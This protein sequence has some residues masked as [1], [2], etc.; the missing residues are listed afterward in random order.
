MKQYDQTALL[1]QQQLTVLGL[2]CNPFS[3]QVDAGCLYTDSILDMTLN[4][5]VQSL[6]RNNQTI[7]L[8]AEQGAGK[9]T[10]LRKA[11]QLTH[12]QFQSCAV[13]ATNTL[14][15]EQLCEK[16]QTKWQ[17]DASSQMNSNLSIEN[18]LI[19]Y[20]EKHPKCL[21]ILDDAHVLDA[22]CLNQLFD[23]KNRLDQTHPNALFFIFSGET[24]LKLSLIHLDDHVSY[25]CNH[26]QINIRS[27][28]LQQT[29]SYVQY[30]IR[31][32]MIKSD[33]SHEDLLNMHQCE[34]IYKSSQGNFDQIHKYGNSY[35]HQKYANLTSNLDSQIHP[36]TQKNI[37]SSRFTSKKIMA[38]FTLLL[39]SLV[40]LLAFITKT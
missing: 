29:M 34:N 8:L 3:A 12:S 6:A 21:L 28:N 13:R 38:I 7:V 27:L 32:C 2:K 26:L 18:Y 37:P 17:L 15:F 25:D 30:R 14:N 9:T 11:L 23:L 4:V 39:I 10:F 36:A 35:L 1:T 19:C 20:F 33:Q 16:M 5:I 24:P 22:V 40:I 31:Q